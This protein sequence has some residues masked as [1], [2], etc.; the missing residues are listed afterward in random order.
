MAWPQ[1]GIGDGDTVVAYDDAGGV[2]A[3]RLVWMLRA[4]GHDAALLDGGL[5]AWPADDLHPDYPRPRPPA[6]FTAVPWPAERLARDRRGRGHRRGA[7]RRARPRSASAAD[8]TPST[9]ARA[10]SPAP[11]TCR[12]A[13]TSTPTPGSRPPSSCATTFAQAG[14]EP[15]TPRDLLLRLRRHRLPQ[16]ARA[17]A[18]RPRP[19]AALSRAPGRSGA[20]TPNSPIETDDRQLT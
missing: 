9:R 19:G 4:I 3:A 16:P 5:A 15:G 12:R 20:A 8:R 11:A 2:I 10:T 14:I 1:L 13:S 18:R 7:D 6:S 17:R